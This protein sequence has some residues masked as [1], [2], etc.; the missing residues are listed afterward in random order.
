LAALAA[1]LKGI[2]HA[3]MQH[4]PTTHHPPRPPRA[5]T[6]H[7]HTYTTPTTHHGQLHISQQSRSSPSSDGPQSPSKE[8]SHP[9]LQHP[10][11]SSDSDDGAWVPPELAVPQN[12]MLAVY[13][14]E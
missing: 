3:I 13:P 9:D 5:P 14:G 7:T 8:T 4:T 1:M 2:P 10:S 6:T 11:S 12:L